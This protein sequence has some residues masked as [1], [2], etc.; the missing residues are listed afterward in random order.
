MPDCR[1]DLS[2][3]YSAQA[4]LNAEEALYWF[5]LMRSVRSPHLARPWIGSHLFYAW[6]CISVSLTGLQVG[7][8]WAFYKPGALQTQLNAQGMTGGLIEIM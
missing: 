2:V 5:H 1:A 7:L 8:P 3:T 6:P 4:S